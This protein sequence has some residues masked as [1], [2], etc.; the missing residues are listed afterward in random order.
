MNWEHQR[1]TRTMY[2]HLVKSIMVLRSVSVTQHSL[3]YESGNN[4]ELW[5]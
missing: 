5:A 1:L 2:I 4:A 3:L